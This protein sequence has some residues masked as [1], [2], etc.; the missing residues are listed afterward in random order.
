MFRTAQRQLAAGLGVVLD[1]P[2]ARPCLYQAA[3]QAARQAG[4][5]PMG[6]SGPH[7]GG[8]APPGRREANCP[9]VPP[10]AGPAGATTV[11]SAQ[12]A[13][14]GSGRALAPAPAPSA[15]ACPGA[16]V[17]VVV[18][19]VQC[20]DEAL[21]RQRL[22]ARGA[23]DAGTERA[24]KPGA[25]EELQALLRRYDGSWRWSTDGSVQLPYHV[26]VDT[27]VAGTEECV[28]A[29]LSYLRGLSTDDWR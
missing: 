24:H 1:C 28:D 15:A 3:L 10:L 5:E 12:A 9:G 19:D 6:V 16:P 4:L 23:G 25:W 2:F 22:E 18:V 11:S 29:V 27:A 21:W 17:R 13:G 20:S 26:R 14:G 7:S 8:A